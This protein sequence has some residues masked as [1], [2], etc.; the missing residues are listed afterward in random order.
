VCIFE[1]KSK[2]H[3]VREARR[4]AK[5]CAAAVA[6][7][8]AA[9]LAGGCVTVRPEQRAIL[10]DPVMQFQGDPRE[11]AQRQHVLENREGSFGGSS[12]QG[13]GCGCN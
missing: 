13:G 9:L 8:A 12:V 2:E 5:R 4:N 1:T 7:L 3:P 6:L 11:A 10:A